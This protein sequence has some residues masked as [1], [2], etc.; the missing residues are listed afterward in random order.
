[1]P[2]SRF[3]GTIP[4]LRD[5]ASIGTSGRC[6]SSGTIPL[7]RDWACTGSMSSTPYMIIARGFGGR[8]PA[9]NGGAGGSARLLRVQGAS[10]CKIRQYGSDKGGSARLL[11]VQG[12]STCKIRRYGSGKGG[13]RPPAAGAGRKRLHN[14]PIRSGWVGRSAL[15]TPP[16]LFSICYNV[17]PP[18]FTDNLGKDPVLLNKGV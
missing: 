10:A 3:S 7:L 5:C 2:S 12:A 4:L 8:A 9:P 11:R 1:M 6:S 15:P 17:S 16:Y 14:P 13:Q 18:F